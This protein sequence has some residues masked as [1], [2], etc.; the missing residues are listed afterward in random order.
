MRLISATSIATLFSLLPVAVTAQYLGP[1]PRL[2]D[3]IVIPR[4]ALPKSAIVGS[5]I[6]TQHRG[7]VVGQFFSRWWPYLSVPAAWTGS[8][9]GCVA[10]DISS[11]RKDATITSVNYYRAMTGLPDTV[12][13]NATF[14][15]NDQQM[16]LMISANDQLS[17][18]PP[19]S[20]WVR[21]D[22]TPSTCTWTIL[23]AE[24][25]P[26]GTGAGFSIHRKHRWGREMWKAGMR[27][28]RGMRL[29]CSTASAA[30]LLHRNGPRGRRRV[31]FPTGSCHRNP[32]AGHSRIPMR[33]FPERPSR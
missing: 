13:L 29:A 11:A 7:E 8:V 19:P 26:L 31:L 3:S 17:H 20:R 16:A 15:G 33:I 22:R 9:A 27:R 12:A 23:A 2:D 18:T 21:V 28:N 30:G 25:T 4:T 10:G 24:T 32:I 6:N 5:P 1:A 14:N